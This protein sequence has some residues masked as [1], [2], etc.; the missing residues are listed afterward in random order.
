MNTNNTYIKPITAI[1]GKHNIT[2]GL[3]IETKIKM[4]ARNLN[5]SKYDF[6]GFLD[7]TNDVVLRPR[8]YNVRDKQGRF[9]A[10]AA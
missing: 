2:S 4:I 10:V 1:T 7:R 3:P 9:A 5:Q 6:L 8:Y